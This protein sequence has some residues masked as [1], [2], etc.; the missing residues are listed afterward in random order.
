[1][2]YP[3]CVE[4]FDQYEGDEDDI[5]EFVDE[6]YKTMPDDATLN[7]VREIEGVAVNEF[8]HVDVKEFVDDEMAEHEELNK[9]RRDK[10]QPLYTKLKDPCEV[11][12]NGNS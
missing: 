1:M 2:F 11:I 3:G 9:L 8:K 6:N 10:P 7:T 12:N 4:V 5:I